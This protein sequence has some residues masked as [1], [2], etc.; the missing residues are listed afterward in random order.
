MRGQTGTE[1][2]RLFESV[3]ACAQDDA[4]TVKL[5]IS[6]GA[7]ANRTTASGMTPLHIAVMNNKLDAA[8]SL[9]QRGADPHAPHGHTHSCIELAEHLALPEMLCM[10]TQTAIGLSVD[11]ALL[12]S[13]QRRQARAPACDSRAIV[14]WKW[15]KYPGLMLTG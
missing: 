1:G 13:D 11:N 6:H 10:L 12:A 3:C 4:D 9:L 5:L 15:I 2:K 14:P 7:D 8:R